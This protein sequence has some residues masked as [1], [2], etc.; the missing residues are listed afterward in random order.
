MKI[1]F[2][3][4]DRKISFNI[5]YRKRKTT[6]LEI[7]PDGTI[8]VLA[9]NGLDKNFII[10]KVNEKS[11]WIIK[12]LDELKE[13]NDKIQQKHYEDGDIFLYLGKEYKLKIIEDISLVGYKVNL[14]GEFLIVRV[15]TNNKELIKNV[16]KS[17]YGDETLRLS[18]ERI[19][20]YK[21]YFNDNVSEIKIK[22]QKT[23][24]A[25]CTYKNE[26]LFNLRCAMAPIEIIDYI[27]VH[28]M[29]HMEHRNHSKYFY[30]AIERILP[31]YKNRIKWLKE[32]GLKMNF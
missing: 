10:S 26:I 3:H 17:W 16:L 9:P 1:T 4:K 15:N 12:K 27:V 5:I 13:K 23:R 32:N 7:K 30:L 21:S 25:S 22:D 11:E 8:N 24:W 20:Y 2:M 18:K 19:D 28:E 29:C 6:S 14:E 31:D